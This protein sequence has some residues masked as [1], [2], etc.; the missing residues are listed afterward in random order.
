MEQI[1]TIVQFEQRARFGSCISRGKTLG[2]S[3]SRTSS[4]V[5]R[6]NLA[7]QSIELL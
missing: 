3:M 2:Q 6:E 4:F 7:K 1:G 5:G